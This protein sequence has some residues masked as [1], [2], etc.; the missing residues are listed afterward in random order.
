ME[1]DKLVESALGSSTVADGGFIG[2]LLTLGTAHLK[3]QEE[4]FVQGEYAVAY[5][6]MMGQAMSEGIKLAMGAELT[7]WQVELAAEQVNTQKA[8]TALQEKSLTALEKDIAI[9]EQDEF[10]KME[11]VNT[12]KAETGIKE[13]DAEIKE[14][15]VKLT[16]NKTNL[17]ET[18]RLLTERQK[19]AF[20]EDKNQRLL[21]TSLNAYSMIF[22]DLGDV[23]ADDMPS[24]ISTTGI[25][26]A[27]SKLGGKLKS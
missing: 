27:W 26:D 3:T 2:K 7:K 1:I 21:S 18:Q 12:Q 13:K 11:Q 20:D 22:Q 6:Q 10:I 9:K 4:K 17:T 25:N 5:T 16:K 14:E 15:T 19:T 23:V 24:A 8:E